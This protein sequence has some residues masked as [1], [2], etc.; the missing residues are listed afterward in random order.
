M[1]KIISHENKG[2]IFMF[3]IFFL[4]LAGWFYWFQWRPSEIRKNCLK[5]TIAQSKINSSGLNT[6]YKVCLTKHGMKT[7]SIE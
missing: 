5:E 2:K 6:Y 3:L 1:I 4:L 7:E